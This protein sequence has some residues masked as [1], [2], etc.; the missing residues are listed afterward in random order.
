MQNG[1]VID[2]RRDAAP[3]KVLLSNRQYAA[4]RLFTDERSGFVMEAGH[5]LRVDQRSFGSL[6]HRGYIRFEKDRGGFVLTEAGRLARQVFDGT[7][8]FRK[9]PAT[10]FSFYLHAIK[11]LRRTA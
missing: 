4:L 1:K 8:V 6:Y 11:A 2:L 5:A 7:D 10:S 3:T 9:E